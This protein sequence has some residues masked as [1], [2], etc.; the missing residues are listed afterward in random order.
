[1]KVSL[2]QLSSESWDPKQRGLRA[3]R[4]VVGAPYRRRRQSPPAAICWGV[5]LC[6]MQTHRLHFL[7]EAETWSY[8]THTSR[9]ERYHNSF[10]C[11]QSPPYGKQNIYA[12][13]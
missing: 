3:R 2:I 12:Y 7:T 6:I 8:H 4:V 11:L 10:R 1:M 13:I 9:Q 5:A